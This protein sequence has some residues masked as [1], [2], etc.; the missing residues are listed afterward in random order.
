MA[1]RGASGATFTFGV[2]VVDKR[3]PTATDRIREQ[4]RWLEENASPA[5]P[6]LANPTTLSEE[7]DPHEYSMERLFTP[8]PQLLNHGAVLSEMLRQLNEHVWARPAVVAPNW[9]ATYEKILRLLTYL[10][11]DEYLSVGKNLL[12]LFHLVRE[13]KLEACLTHGDPTFD[14]V[15]VREATGELVLVDPIPATPAVPDL[16]S[17]D[18]GK[19]LQSI[20]GW[21]RV[22]Y[23]RDQAFV[24][25]I[26]ALRMRIPLDVEWEATVMWCAVHLLRTLPYHDQHE[27]VTGLVRT[28]LGLL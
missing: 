23:G 25:G 28:T 14:N 15:M 7:R 1:R 22:R 11:E 5:V 21:E 26:S 4:A 12:Q 17:V 6:R 2:Y 20:V 10:P 27:E 16:R 18:T 13:S 3:H 19:I 8:P 9:G 24:T